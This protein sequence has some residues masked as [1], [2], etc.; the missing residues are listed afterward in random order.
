MMPRDYH[1][2]SP[3]TTIMELQAFTERSQ[4]SISL[5]LFWDTECRA[6]NEEQKWQLFENKAHRKVMDVRRNK[7]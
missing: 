2:Q 6:L 7:R 3:Q 4:T 5:F 1:Q